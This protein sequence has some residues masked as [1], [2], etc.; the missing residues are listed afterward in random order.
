MNLSP[1][2][3]DATVSDLG[4]RYLAR[5]TA[6][7]DEETVKRNLCPSIKTVTDFM[8]DLRL[9][10]VTT[11][12][13]DAFE[14]HL[15]EKFKINTVR[16]KLAIAKGLFLYAVNLE[17]IPLSPFRLIK[18]PKRENVGINLSDEILGELLDM[19]PHKYHRACKIA[20]YTGMR[21][22]EVVY[23]D[24]DKEVFDDHIRLPKE[25]TKSGVERIIPIGKRVWAILGRRGHGRV[26]DF[27]PETL[28]GYMVKAWHKLG[29]GRIRFHDLR[30]TSYSRFM[31]KSP[32]LKAAME[33][34]GW[35]HEQS[36]AP[37]EHV[38]ALRKEPLLKIHYRG[39]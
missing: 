8:G 29:L 10:H 3:G 14:T 32:D 16:H 13:A 7:L 12:R 34:F 26:F 25:R 4:E 9:R 27:C 15:F 28:T 31:D 21:R 39:I 19:L 6:K 22:N 36:V 5:A 11:E 17:A 38:T 24:W 30:H 37:Y 33:I 2:N 35:A 18:L 20:L 23:L 1:L